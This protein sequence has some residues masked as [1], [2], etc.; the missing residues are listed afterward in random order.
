MLLRRWRTVRGQ[1]R[2]ALAGQQELIARVELLDSVMR[3]KHLP[4]GAVDVPAELQAAQAA[5]PANGNQVV[6]LD[7]GD[8]HLIAV[9]GAEPGDLGET[10]DAIRQ[11]LDVTRVAMH[12]DPAS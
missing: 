8:R 9:I 11:D 2:E 5:A 3:M 10:W 4:V 1:L 12:G 6:Q 7:V